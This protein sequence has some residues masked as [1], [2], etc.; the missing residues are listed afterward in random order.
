VQAQ[1]DLFGITFLV[2]LPL[3]V[4]FPEFKAGLKTGPKFYDTQKSL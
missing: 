2:L 4:V 3:G 1:M